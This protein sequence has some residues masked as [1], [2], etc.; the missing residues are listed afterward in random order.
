[1][2]KNIK[3]WLF[4]ERFQFGIKLANGYNRGLEK[5]RSIELA[6]IIA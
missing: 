2:I 4:C 1:M 5:R 6:L 3:L